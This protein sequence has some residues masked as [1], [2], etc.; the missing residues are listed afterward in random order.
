M[1]E[2][3]FYTRQYIMIQFNMFNNKILKTTNENKLYVP[4]CI[5]LL[6]TSTS[7]QKAA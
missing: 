7:I 4:P 2:D 3:I 1:Y 5:T 6:Q